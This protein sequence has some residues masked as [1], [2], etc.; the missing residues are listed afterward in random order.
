MACSV[1]FSI[2]DHIV[3][4]NPSTRKRQMLP[5]TPVEVPREPR[6]PCPDDGRVE[7]CFC[8]NT[9]YDF[10]YD[11]VNDDYKVVRITQLYDK[12]DN[13]SF[14]SIVKIYSLKS[15]SW[16]RIQ[17]FPYYFLHNGPDAALASGAF[18][19]VVSRKPYSDTVRLIAA[20]DL[21]IEQYR[22]VPL[23]E[24]SDENFRMYVDVLGGCLSLLCNYARVRAE[25]WVMKEYG[26]KESWT[27]LFCVAQPTIIRSFRYVRTLAYSKTGEKVLMQRDDQKLLWYDLGKKRIK[28]LKIR[29]RLVP[30][31]VEIYFE[32]LVPLRES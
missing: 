12:D 17:D 14:D 28:K 1:F 2:D 8:P 6:C 29:S 7:R 19:W 10:G 25:V 16:R 3:L 18:H 15:N 30:D 11:S 27:K 4:L 13:D 24:F 5:F 31:E 23:P 20:F 26:V 32:S 22:L 9:A 21:G